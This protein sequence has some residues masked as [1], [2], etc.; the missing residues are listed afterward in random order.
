[1]SW[2]ALV[3]LASS[4]V[5]DSLLIR[6]SG[7]S[8]VDTQVVTTS[9]S[10]RA[11]NHHHLLAPLCGTLLRRLSVSI[12]TST[13]GWQVRLSEPQRCSCLVFICLAGDTLTP[14]PVR[15]TP[16]LLP[17]SAHCDLC[18][19]CGL[20]SDPSHLG[21]SLLAHTQRRHLTAQSHRRR[22]G[23]CDGGAKPSDLVSR[24]TTSAHRLPPPTRTSGHRPESAGMGQF[25]ATNLP[26]CPTCLQLSAP[27]VPLGSTAQRCQAGHPAAPATEA[28]LRRRCP[29]NVKTDT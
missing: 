16:R 13:P 20:P 21:A 1:M 14:S 8:G 17:S 5:N 6:V 26:T 28:S 11:V 22:S 29:H 10:G 15:A 3:L 23:P 9:H 2:S 25:R 24:P 19:L 12:R 7:V 18:D 27:L 4:S